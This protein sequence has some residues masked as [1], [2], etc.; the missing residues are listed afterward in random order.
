MKKQVPQC[1][2][3]CEVSRNKVEGE[4][5]GSSKQPDA[6]H[7]A[8]QKFIFRVTSLSL[9][10]VWKKQINTRSYEYERWDIGSVEEEQDTETDSDALMICKQ[11][12]LLGYC[13]CCCVG[14]RA[15]K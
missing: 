9:P 1:A 13:V 10:L 11:D 6:L 12:A 14:N 2:D 4:H 3:V 8:V 7:A 15:Y 5:M